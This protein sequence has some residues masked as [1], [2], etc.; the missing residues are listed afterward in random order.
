MTSYQ[1]VPSGENGDK[2]ENVDRFASAKR[3]GGLIFL[4]VVVTA[5]VLLSPTGSTEAIEEFTAFI[6]DEDTKLF[7]EY[8]RYVLHDFD[9]KPTFAGFLPGVAGLYGKPLWSFYVNRGQGVASFGTQSKEFPILEFNAANKAYQL[10]PFIGFRSF[11]QAT[12][13][14]STRIF[15]PF[16]PKN[17]RI[18]GTDNIGLPKRT[19]FIGTNDMEVKEVDY[20]NGLTT[21]AKYVVLP[22]EDFG[23]LIRRTTFTNIG[24]DSVT[25]SALDGLAKMEPSG[26]K[27]DWGLKNMGRTLEGWMGVYHAD[28]TLSMPFY[29]MSTEPGDSASVKIETAGHYCISFIEDPENDAELLPII[30]DSTKVF[31]QNTPLDM[32]AG[33]ITSSVADIVSSTQYGDARTSS[34]FA[35]VDSYTLLPGESVTIASFYGKTD[36]IANVPKIAEKVSSANYVQSKYVRAR[37]LMNEITASVTTTTAN[38]LFDGAVKQMYMDNGLRGGLP[39]ILGDVDEK[40]QMSNA[41]ED[42][43]LKVYHTFSRIHG[44]LERDYNAFMIDPTYYS[45]GP[46]NYRDVAQNRR[47]DVIFYPRMGG[48]DVKQFLSY[49]QA[50]GYEPLTVEAMAYLIEDP[51]VAQEVADKVC[52]DERSNNILT[53]VLSGGAFRPGQLFALNDQL[54]IAL[55]VDND[56]FINEVMAAANATEMALYGSGYWADHWEYYLD[57]INNYLAIYPDGEEQLMYDN[58]LRYFFST[59]TVKPRSEKYVLDLTQDGKGKH[60]LQL[61]STTFDEEKVAEQEAYRNTN[62][63]IIGTD[64]YWQRIAGGGAA[65]KSTP[66]AKL[67]LLGTIKFATRDAY[68]MGI[69]YEGGRPGWNDAMNGLPGM[70]GSGMP[71]TYEMY[72]LLKYVKKVADT[73]SRGIVIPTELADLVQKIEAAQDLLESTGYQ[74]PEDLPLDVPPELFN[75]W[76][77][78]AAAREDYRNN[79]Q[80]YFNGTTVELSAD[81]VSSMLS[82]W[83]SQVELG[84]ARAMKIASRGMN[85]DGT[86]GVPPAYFSYNVTKWVKNGGKNDKGLPLVNAKA[87]KVGTFPLFLEGPVRY[88][89]TVTDEETKGN[90]YD[91]VMASGLR[92]HGLNMYFI[93]ADLKGQ[94]YD[95]GRMM[96]FASG[97]LENHSIWLHMSYKYY[98]ELIRGNLYDQFF[99]EMRGGGMLPFMDPDVYGRS[100]MECSSFLASSAFPD[101]ATQGRGFSARLSGSTAEFLSMWVLMFIGPE[102]FILADDGS[103]QMQLVPALPSWLFEDLDDDLPGTYDED[104]NLIVT[105][106]LF[107]SIIVTYHNSEG[108]NLY[109]VSPNSYK[110][111]KD[112]GTSVT[113][114]GGVIPTDEAIAIR[115]VFGIVSIDAYF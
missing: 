92:D 87:M 89:K 41:D 1:K 48:F 17:S 34:A 96:A 40:S 115:K 9:A 70:V 109:G 94:S 35:A 74:D 42:P 49:I 8:N 60:V 12:R 84:M 13:G 105:F 2:V 29:R 110:I 54:D 76:D 102:P 45:Q 4:A 63:G 97:W 50:D 107:R 106:K 28:D 111:T 20:E 93:S 56:R 98:L 30:Y 10:T 44:D 43:R 114:D 61:D 24:L 5:A 75:Y 88:M 23:A 71:E 95:M 25:L 46:G 91:L 55:K 113:V 19:Q 16:S 90:M 66:I 37:T 78:V 108:G 85:D 15:E 73:Y 64:A 6:P 82:R 3:Y 101:P 33:L 86:S 32:P 26:G 81:D 99:S 77:V 14:D 80:Y 11:V 39:N 47:N 112:D 38:P 68:G 103:L 79:V 62:T 65:F 67:F 21:T 57:L 36:D 100:L 53:A 31:G 69:E 83:I 7:D 59:A 51:E 52:A 58:E 18:I 22:E 27:L 104:G 72:L